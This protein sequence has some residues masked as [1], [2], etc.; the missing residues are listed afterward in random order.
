M[1]WGQKRSPEAQL[2]VLKW[3]LRDHVRARWIFQGSDL[4]RSTVTLEVENRTDQVLRFIRLG[5]MGAEVTAHSTHSDTFYPSNLLLPEEMQ[6]SGEA[7]QEARWEILDRFPIV[8]IQPH[9]RYWQTL[10]P[11]N[12]QFHILD[13]NPEIVFGATLTLFLGEN[14]DPMSALYPVRLPVQ[15]SHKF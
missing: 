9:D 6:V 8:K 10:Y 14:N 3:D 11:A 4:P 5:A 7:A 12:V 15:G 1:E 2:T 13:T